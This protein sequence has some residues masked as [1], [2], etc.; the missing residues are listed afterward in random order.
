MRQISST[1]PVFHE[2]ESQLRPSDLCWQN[3][4]SILPRQDYLIGFVPGDVAQPYRRSVSCADQ[5]NDGLIIRNKCRMSRVGRKIISITSAQAIGFITDAQFQ[6]ATDDPVRLIF[7]VRVWSILRAGGIARL[8]D[9]VAFI[10]QSSFQLLGFGDAGFSP[11]LNFNAHGFTLPQ[12]SQITQ[13]GS[14]ITWF[15]ISMQK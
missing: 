2:D 3:T 4:L 15:A 6:F 10:D 8:K 14:S 9:A 1:L 11:A 13:P 7:G 5:V 12:A